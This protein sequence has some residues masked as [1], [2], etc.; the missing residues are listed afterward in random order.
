MDSVDSEST[1]LPIFPKGTAQ[2]KLERV[3]LRCKTGEKGPNTMWQL[4]DV[5][6][7]VLDCVFSREPEKPEMRSGV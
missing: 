6:W 5:S 7:V 3:G 4:W 2:R 1:F